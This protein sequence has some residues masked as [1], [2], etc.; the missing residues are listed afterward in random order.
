VEDDPYYYLQEGEYHPKHSRAQLLQY[1]NESEANSAFLNSLIPSYL[2]LDYQGRVIR[3]ESF[4]KTIAPGSRLGWYTGHPT[5]M[6]R[7][8]RI[9]ES[10]SQAPSGFSQVLITQLLTKVWGM[11]GY[12]TWLRGLQHDYTARRDAM[13]DLFVEA[14]D[15]KKSNDGSSGSG[16][17]THVGFPKKRKI[18]REFSAEKR[19]PLISLT[20]PV[21]GMYIW[22][23]VNLEI[24]EGLDKSDDPELNTPEKRLWDK[25]AEAGVL[26]GPGYFFAADDNDKRTRKEAHFRISYSYADLNLMK[27]AVG[28]IA[29]VL[30]EHV[31]ND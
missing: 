29:K 5:F 16:S 18:K 7:F 10:S 31:R 21:A 24:L 19:Q 20:P 26:L 17:D 28:L 9:T 3:L 13:L 12:I 11:D 14:F 25:F 6:E 23:K 15:L 8:E 22:M 30:N 2:R 1:S 4:S 27:K